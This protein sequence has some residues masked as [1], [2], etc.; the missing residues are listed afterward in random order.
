M[1][2]VPTLNKNKKEKDNTKKGKGFSVP[3]NRFEWDDVSSSKIIDKF[4]F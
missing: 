4:Y 3:L 2:K 1:F